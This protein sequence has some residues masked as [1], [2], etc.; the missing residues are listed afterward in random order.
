MG[1]K[2]LVCGMTRLQRSEQTQLGRLTMWSVRVSNP[3]VS[4]CPGAD[5]ANG[6]LSLTSRE[7]D[8]EP[9][10]TASFLTQHVGI[11]LLVIFS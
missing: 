1:Y 3:R 5:I 4:C 6:S 7:G 10:E 2:L 11:I 9:H 8:D